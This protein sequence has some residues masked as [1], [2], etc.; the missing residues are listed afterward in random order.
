M[1]AELDNFEQELLMDEQDDAVIADFLTE[2]S[3]S[4]CPHGVYVA[5]GDSYARYCT[6]CNPGHG[7]IMAPLKRVALPSRVERTLDAAEYFE[8]PLSERL[9]LAEQ[10]GDMT[11]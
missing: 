4:K 11:S 1:S 8:L 6:A 2:H 5:K 9:A 10:L 3:D 7:R